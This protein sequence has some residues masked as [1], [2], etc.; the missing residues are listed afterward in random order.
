MTI[1][2][3][4]KQSVSQI[5]ELYDGNFSDGWSQNMLNSGFDGGRLFAFGVFNEQ[6]LVGV[7]TFS[8]GVDDADI[9]G[10]V[11]DKNYRGKG[12]AQ[13]LIESAH[14]FIKEKGIQKV[15]L[16]V[17]QTNTPAINLYQKVGYKQ[18]SVRKNYYSDGENALVL[19]KEF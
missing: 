18:I 19:I 5:L 3:L 11:V 12:L 17:R 15:L 8:L 1:K 13:S 7:I 14:S 4:S 6:Q 2:S 16:E 10:V 9:E